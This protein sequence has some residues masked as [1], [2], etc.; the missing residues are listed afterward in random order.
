MVVI[1][2]SGSD[3]MVVFDGEIGVVVATW[4]WW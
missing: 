1:D 3:E 4:E 2:R